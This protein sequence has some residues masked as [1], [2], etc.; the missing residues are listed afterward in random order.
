MTAVEAVRSSGVDVNSLPTY[1]FD[2]LEDLVTGDGAA[3][4]QSSGDFL[5]LLGDNEE[6]DEL[7]DIEVIAKKPTRPRAPRA[8]SSSRR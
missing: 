2:D 6:D 1:T 4:Q 7:C 5:N 8:R 3:P